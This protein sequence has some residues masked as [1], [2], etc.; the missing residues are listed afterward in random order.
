MEL[1]GEPQREI[2]E[3]KGV[4]CCRI[5]QPMRLLPTSQ[6]ASALA[7]AAKW[8]NALIDKMNSKR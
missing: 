3:L 7:R 6:P 2:D 4:L 1:S 5:S 8:R